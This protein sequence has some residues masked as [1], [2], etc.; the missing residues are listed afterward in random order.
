MVIVMTPHATQAQIE[1]V[2]RILSEYGFAGHMI[3]G[4]NR[5]VIGAVG[6]RQAIASLGL[7]TLAG[8]E[9][10]VPIRRPYKL[11][12]REAKEENTI[13]HVKDVAIGGDEVTVIAGPCAI[14]SVEQVMKAAEEVRR[15][16]GKILRGGA[17]KPRTSP[18]A[19]QGLEEEGLKIMRTAG[20]FAGLPTVSEVIDEPSLELACQYLDMVQIGAR[21]MQNFRLLQAVGRARIPVILKRGLSATIEEWLM[22]AEYILSEGNSQVILCERGI[23]TYETATRNT[24]DLSAIPLVKELSHLPILVDPSHSTGASRLVKSM[25]KAAVA[26]GADGLLV[27]VHPDP[28]R[29]LCD[30]PQSLDPEGFES[31]MKEL[32]PVA[33]AVNRGI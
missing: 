1:K 2:N 22:A 9:K 15:C 8:V 31:L 33:H 12:S 6:D 25:S 14:E 30:G 26:A 4:V 7:E 13:V 27:E 29:A 24:L 11:V 32:T 17:F 20:R 28:C 19:F 21:N 3:T 10:V 18:Y 23:R 16:G 5:I